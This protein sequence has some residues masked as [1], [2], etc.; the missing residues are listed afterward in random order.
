MEAIKIQN[1]TKINDYKE[2]DN[3]EL[4]KITMNTGDKEVLN[5]LILYGY[6]T[7]FGNVNENMEVYSKEAITGYIEKYFVKNKLNIPV[8][9]MHRDDIFHLCGRVLVVEAN[10]VGFYFVAYVPKT[11]KYYQLVVDNIKEQILQGFSKEGW[12]TDYEYIY[13]SDGTFDH[14]LIKEMAFCKLSIVDTPANSISF[15]SAKET[16]IKNAT[17]F[18]KN[19]PAKDADDLENQLFN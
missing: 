8:T 4:S 17:K 11:Y 12:A 3:L 19:T 10:N 16:V 9:L 18:I 14:M 5:G 6:E 2:V 13:K 15:E 1:T 7:K